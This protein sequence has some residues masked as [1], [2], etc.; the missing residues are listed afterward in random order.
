LVFFFFFGGCGVWTQSLSLAR[1][2]FYYL[3]YAPSPFSF[4][5]FWNKVSYVCLDCSPVCVSHVAEWQVSATTPS[6]W[7]RRNLYLLN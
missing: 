5:Y 6:C 2:A 3:S 7:L 4:G 1:Q